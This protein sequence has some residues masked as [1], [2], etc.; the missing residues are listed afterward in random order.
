MLPRSGLVYC[1]RTPHA[2]VM[3]KPRIMAIKSLTLEKLEQMQQEAEAALKA[4]AEQEFA[5]Q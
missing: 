4:K 5:E 2:E 3:C 1:E